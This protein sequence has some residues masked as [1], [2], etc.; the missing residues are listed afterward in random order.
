MGI[1]ICF[2]LEYKVI[3]RDIKLTDILAAAKK[4]KI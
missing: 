4:I 1:K 3:L 2:F